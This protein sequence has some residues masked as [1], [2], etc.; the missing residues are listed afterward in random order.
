[1]K[2][3]EHVIIGGG[4]SG[5]LIGYHLEDSIILEREAITGGR[6]KSE[7]FKGYNMILVRNFYLNLW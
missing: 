5:F 1:M 6:I 4:I 2:I 7:K 3:Y